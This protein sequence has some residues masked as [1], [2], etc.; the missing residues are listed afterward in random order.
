[1][2]PMRLATTSVPAIPALAQIEGHVTPLA[3]ATSFQAAFEDVEET[4]EVDEVVVTSNDTHED[5]ETDPELRSDVVGP[6]PLMHQ[7]TPQAAKS[8][9]NHAFIQAPHNLMHLPIVPG[10]TAGSVTADVLTMTTLPQATAVTTLQSAVA[11]SANAQITRA[12]VLPEIKQHATGRTAPDQQS[13]LEPWHIKTSLSDG[14]TSPKM[15]QAAGITLAAQPN[16]Q[17]PIQGALNAVANLPTATAPDAPSTQGP[18]VTVQDARLQ[19]GVPANA[20]SV[21]WAATSQHFLADAESI[22]R[23]LT[24]APFSTTRAEATLQHTQMSNPTRADLPPHIARQLADVVAQMPNRPVEITLSPEVLGRV[25]LTLKVSDTGVVV[26]LL[27]ERPETLDLMRRHIDQ[28]GQDFKAL[29]YDDIAFSFSG[30]DT[31]ANTDGSPQNQRDDTFT[32]SDA[33]AEI[34]RIELR[35][36]ATSGLDLRL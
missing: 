32:H 11:G 35:S 5:E 22:E 12:P 30:E 23:Q 7:T 9:D 17:V 15:S 3:P 13:K 4:P 19:L 20:A 6:A 1:M 14:A 16:P 26:N 31:D 8:P 28:L 10:S 24:D 29:G 36:A 34:T 33:P 2:Q 27:A 18:S 25:R 21:Q